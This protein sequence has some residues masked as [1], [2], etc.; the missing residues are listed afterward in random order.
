[1]RSEFIKRYLNKSSEEVKWSDLNNF[2]L[3]GI[4]E[5]L[6]LE[7]KPRGML[8][9][10]KGKTLKPKNRYDISGFYQ[11]AKLIAGFANSSGGLL[12]LGVK[13][14]PEKHKGQIIKI[15]PGSFSE[16]PPTI[17]REMIEHN[18][19]AKIQVSIDEITIISVRKTQRSKNCV[20][21][22]DVPPSDRAPH[23]VNEMHYYQRHNFSTVEMQHYQ[24]A[25]M[26]GRRIK[27]DLEV[28]L[29]DINLTINDPENMPRN[30]TINVSLNIK[31]EGRA[32]AK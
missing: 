6:T 3:E 26:F 29:I 7:Y 17:T 20:Y 10:K 25:D 28:A 8:V 2:I 5:N 23:R 15:R 18:L 31:N 13:E 16:I 1:M 12:V 4:E 22:I 11:L 14:K 30:K 9:D 24:I 19:E 21:L 32:V 27:P